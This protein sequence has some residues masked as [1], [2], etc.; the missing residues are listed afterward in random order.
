MNINPATAPIVR[1]VYN[2]S[3]NIRIIDTPHA[4]HK[5]KRCLIFFSGNGLYFP[6]TDECFRQTI[7]E[8]DRYEWANTAKSEL[9]QRNTDRIILV[10]DILKQWY[11]E[12][13]NAKLYTVE[14][15]AKHLKELSSGYIVETCGNSAGGYAAVLFGCLLCAR[16]VFSVS[17]QFVLTNE[18]IC[19]NPL[20]QKHKDDAAYSR[21][22]DTRPFLEHYSGEVIYA[23]PCLWKDDIEQAKMVQGIRQVRAMKVRASSHG[24]GLMTVNY[25]YLFFKRHIRVITGGGDYHSLLTF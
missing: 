1:E 25:Q 22:F 13:V 9:V 17:G 7:I 20:L 10:R 15:T 16:R 6:N 23:Y 3:E 24:A 12:G 14:L 21:F 5:Y 8:N 19:K 4:Q 11:A 18:Y 2:N